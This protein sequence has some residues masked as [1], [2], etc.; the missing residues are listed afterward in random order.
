LSKGQIEEILSLC[1][2]QS[3]SEEGSVLGGRGN[4][5]LSK[6]EGL[7]SIAVKQY[8]RGGLLGKLIRS[9]YLSF[10]ESRAEEEFKILEMVRGLGIN[11]PQ[12]LI[13]VRRGGAIY[14]NWLIMSAIPDPVSMAQLAL[15]DESGWIGKVPELILQIGQLI[16]HRI[17]H[18]DLHPGNVLLG[19]DGK[20]CI[21]D[22][23]RARFFPGSLNDLRDQYLIRWRRAVIKHQLPESVSERICPGLRVNFEIQEKRSI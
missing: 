17:F 18:V 6:I 9:L 13:W 15:N 2:S 16:R 12:P 20:V 8:R 10:G 1:T 3:R 4:V 19:S 11:A 23:D 7:G 5:R 22:F 21:I 14:E